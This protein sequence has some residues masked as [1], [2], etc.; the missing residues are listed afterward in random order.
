MNHCFH[1]NRRAEPLATRL[2]SAN[3]IRPAGIAQIRWRVGLFHCVES[4]ETRL[5][6][7]RD[8]DLV[9]YGAAKRV[10]RRLR[11]FGQQDKLKADRSKGA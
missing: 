4:N 8:S 1:L 6:L 7:L 9:A 10:L 11:I 3:N 5:V 2:A